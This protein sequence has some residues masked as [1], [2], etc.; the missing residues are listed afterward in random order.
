MN[1]SFSYFILVIT[2]F[3]DI[4]IYSKNKNNFGQNFTGGQRFHRRSSYEEGIRNFFEFSRKNEKV[5]FLNLV[6]LFA[7]EHSEEVLLLLKIV[8]VVVLP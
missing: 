2:I 3:Y 6:T 1:N 8:P 4:V 7:D 5:V